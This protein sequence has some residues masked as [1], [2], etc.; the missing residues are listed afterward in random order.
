MTTTRH[1]VTIKGTKDGLV[2]FMDDTCSFDELI[3][4]LRNK[5]ENSHQQILTGPLIRVTVNL[6]Y[7]YLTDEQEQQ[8]RGII[9]KRGNLVIK[10]FVSEVISREQAYLEQLASQIR[11]EVGT[12]RSGQVLEHQG[13]LLLMG[14]VNPGGCIQSTG[15]IFVLGSLRGTARA[16]MDGNEDAI[17]AASQLLPTQLR[18]ADV[19][20]RPTEE[21]LD[22]TTGMEFAYL[23]DGV[24]NIDKINRLHR[25]RPE[26]KK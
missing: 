26:W 20:S 12:V 3:Q 4:D 23:K 7:R 16:G 6:G 18:I 13:D 8:I 1:K 14:D 15:S 10:E 2:F 5:V 22:Q 17:V 19:I 21:W 25:I 24:M 11:L 9:R